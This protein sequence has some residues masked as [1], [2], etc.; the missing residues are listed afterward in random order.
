MEALERAILL[1]VVVALAVALFWL[2]YTYFYS[3]VKT[4]PTITPPE[5]YYAGNRTLVI[6]I[7]N[8]GPNYAYVDAVFLNDERCNVTSGGEIPPYKTVEVKALCGAPPGLQQY[9]GKVVVNGYA[10]VFNAAPD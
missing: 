10:L 1:G 4:T 6:Y 9:S 5:M 2:A 3:A 8:P 7:Y